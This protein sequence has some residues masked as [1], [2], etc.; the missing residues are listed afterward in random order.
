MPALRGPMTLVALI[1]EGAVTRRILRHLA[2]PD[3]GRAAAPR[4]QGVLESVDRIEWRNRRGRAGLRI[5]R[6]LA[7]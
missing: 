2:L 7:V 6:V 4:D 1:Q 3:V 5:P